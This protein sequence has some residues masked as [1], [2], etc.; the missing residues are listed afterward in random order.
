[1]K[2]FK[3]YLVEETKL[4]TFAFGRFNPPSSG[5]EK[6]FDAVKKLSRGGV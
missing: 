3:D 6:V 1:M 4:V 2:S 5:H